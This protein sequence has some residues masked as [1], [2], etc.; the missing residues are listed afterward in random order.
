MGCSVHPRRTRLPTSYD[1]NDLIYGG[2]LAWAISFWRANLRRVNSD[3]GLASLW[4]V[5]S[6][7][8]S[9]EFLEMG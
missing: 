6:M 7:S 1:A 2:T 4:Q 3:S 5:V 9:N 8:R